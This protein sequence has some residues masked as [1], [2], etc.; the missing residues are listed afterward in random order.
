MFSAGSSPTARMPDQ[1][2]EPGDGASVRGAVFC[3][4]CFFPSQGSHRIGY[5]LQPPE[6]AA[7]SDGR[8]SGLSAVQRPLACCSI[9]ERRLSVY[10]TG[11][12]MPVDLIKE[13]FFRLNQIR[14]G[15]VLRIFSICSRLQNAKRAFRSFS[16][17]FGALSS[18]LWQSVAS[19][20]TKS[21]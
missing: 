19:R 1:R 14:S 21:C 6:D 20:S 15:L 3:G 13:K 18:V 7:A 8:G 17:I 4:I 5:H 12:D 9:R 2:Y 10:W 11:K 16:S